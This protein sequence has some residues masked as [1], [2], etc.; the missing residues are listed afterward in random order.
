[1]NKDSASQPLFFRPEVFSPFPELVAVESTRLGGVSPF[2]FASLNLGLATEDDPEN[3]AQNRRIFFDTLHIPVSDVASAH[4]IHGDGI[5]DVVHGGRWSG[6]DA[7]VTA[8][9]GVFVSITIAD[10]TPVLIYDAQKKVVAAIH[11]GWRGTSLQIVKKTMAY[12][13]QT[14]AVLPSDCFAYV[15][16]CIDECSYEVGADVASHFEDAHKRWDA[17][18]Q[19]FYLNLK[20]ANEQQLLECGIPE[21]QIAQSPYSTVIHN[22]RYFSYRK[23]KGQTGRMLALI[24]VRPAESAR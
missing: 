23:E 3:I 9:P 15:G 16:T 7:L 5:L 12:I 8:T 19:K 24:G 2:P 20:K 6:F 21:N 4:Q 14:Y 18:A 10:C 17:S 1:M 13:Q 22:D 11:A